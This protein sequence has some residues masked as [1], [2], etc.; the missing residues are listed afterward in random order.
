MRSIQTGAHRH[1]GFGVLPLDTSNLTRLAPGLGP[2]ISVCTCTKALSIDATMACTHCRG[3]G[4][5]GLAVDSLFLNS[6]I[7]FNTQNPLFSI[8]MN[9]LK[10]IG[11]R[12]HSNNPMVEPRLSYCGWPSCHGWSFPFNHLYPPHDPTCATAH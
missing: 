2:T 4:P 7:P 1:A 3:L 6:T 8:M 9:P 5:A 11:V 10:K 12:I